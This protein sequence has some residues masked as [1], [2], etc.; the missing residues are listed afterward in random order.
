VL[1]GAILGVIAAAIVINLGVMAFIIV[2][3]MIGRRSPLNAE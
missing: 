2:P 3:P 1:S